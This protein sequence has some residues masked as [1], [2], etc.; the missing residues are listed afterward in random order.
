MRFDKYLF[1][2]VLEFIPNVKQ[3]L[4]AIVTMGGNIIENTPRIIFSFFREKYE[5]LFEI[6]CL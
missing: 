2:A 6:Y 5:K 1:I 4:V 3:K